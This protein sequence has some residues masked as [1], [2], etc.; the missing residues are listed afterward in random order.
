MGIQTSAV[1]I[2]LACAPNGDQC[3]EMRMSE[4]Y[5]TIEDCRAV[6]SATLR[7]IS[8]PGRPVIGR[9][10]SSEAN[11]ALDRTVTNSIKDVATVR[12]TRI[13][14]GNSET[15]IYRVPRGTR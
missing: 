13:T 2:V 14:D 15:S 3:H 11:V 9:C 12:V 10:A 6:L 7:N 4:T 1:L 5:A 8:Q